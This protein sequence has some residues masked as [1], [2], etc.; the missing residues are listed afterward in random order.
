MA[1]VGPQYALLSPDY[2][3]TGLAGQ[4]SVQ[5]PKSYKQM[6]AADLATHINLSKWLQDKEH[7]LELLVEL[8]KY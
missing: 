1:P 5:V 7:V 8:S 2:R 3:V 4:I 6:E